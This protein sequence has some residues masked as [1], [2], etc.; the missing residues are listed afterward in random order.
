[1]KGIVCHRSSGE[2][3]M[4]ST[5]AAAAAAQ[6][7]GKLDGWQQKEDDLVMRWMWTLKGPLYRVMADKSMVRAVESS[8]SNEISR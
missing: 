4:K 6:R 8:E 1:M 3:W 7:G 2:E 5:A